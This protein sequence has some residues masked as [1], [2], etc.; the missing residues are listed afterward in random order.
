MERDASEKRVD[1]ALALIAKAATGAPDAASAAC[2]QLADWRAS[3]AEN[4]AAWAEA[5]H[6]WEMLSALAV[7]LRRHDELMDARRLRRR[8]LLSLAVLCGSTALLGGVGAWY[9]YHPLFTQTYRTAV[10]ELMQ[11]DVP[12]GEGPVGSRIDLNAQTSLTFNLYPGRR[13]AVL[14]EGEV[15]FRVAGDAGRAFLV[16]TRAGVLEAIAAAF[17]VSD[18][19]GPVG[20]SVEYGRV[21]VLAP[22]NGLRFGLRFWNRDKAALDLYGG[23]GVVLR[24]EQADTVQ[25][26]DAAAAAA[27][28]D[29]WLVFDNTSLED[30]IRAVNAYRREP[31]RVVDPATAALRLTGRFRARETQEFLKALPATLPLRAERHADGSV[32]LSRR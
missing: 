5:M 2:G 8:M 17:T 6:R 27:W 19:G 24:D 20:V 11:V 16:E 28:R 25:R 30:A 18:R 22:R 21:R 10:A 15:H 13:V 7:D 1:H 14:A 12:D 31:I 9:A 3:S 29:G 26:V 32:V 23:D 4:E